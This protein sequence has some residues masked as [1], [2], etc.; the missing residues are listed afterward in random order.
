MD[1]THDAE[2]YTFADALRE[3]LAIMPA[4]RTATLM[5]NLAVY[6]FLRTAGDGPAAGDAKH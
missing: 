6:R 2:R 4:E 3:V 1:A 5:R